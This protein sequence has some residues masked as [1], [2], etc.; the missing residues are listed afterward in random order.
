MALVDYVLYHGASSLVVCID[1][2]LLNIAIMHETWDA[3]WHSSR[4]LI[5]WCYLHPHEVPVL[6]LVRVVILVFLY[7]T[8]GV[9]YLL[10]HPL[11]A[12]HGQYCPLLWGTQYST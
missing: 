3:C 2:H 9:V 7:T 10:A 4:Y 11:D 6:H 5:M 8:T 1:N 12:Y